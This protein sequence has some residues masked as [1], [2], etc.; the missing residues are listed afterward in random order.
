MRSGIIKQYHF[1]VLRLIT[2]IHICHR[3]AGKLV[4]EATMF[5][6]LPRN[7]FPL[8]FQSMSSRNAIPFFSLTPCKLP[9]TYH[10]LQGSHQNRRRFLEELKEKAPLD[11]NWLKFILALSNLPP[12]FAVVGIESRSERKKERQ[13]RNACGNGSALT[14]NYS[15]PDKRFDQRVYEVSIADARWSRWLCE[16]CWLYRFFVGIVTPLTTLGNYWGS[17]V[18]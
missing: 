15:G 14:L 17:W 6:V 3:V 18:F 16:V 5:V 7:F 12:R 4:W 13:L 8:S 10:K 1:I 2:E 9:A 11:M